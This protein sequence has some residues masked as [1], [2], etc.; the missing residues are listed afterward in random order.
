MASIDLIIDN[1][2]A[3]LTIN[4][5]AKLNCLTWE[6]LQQLQQHLHTIERAGDS[7]RLCLLTA[8]ESRAFCAGAD[9][10]DW[11]KLSARD[12]SQHWLRQGNRIF[13]HFAQLPMPTIAV[14][15]QAV[16]GGGLELIACCDTR[17]INFKV[18]FALPETA[19]GVI[20]GWSGTQRICHLLPETL[21]KNMVLFGQP[22]NA[23]QAQDSGFAHICEDVYQTANEWQVEVLKR[24]PEANRIAKM[25][26]HAS[27]G[28]NTSDMI[29][30]LGGGFSASTVDK[31]TGVEAFLN[32]KPPVF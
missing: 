1:Q 3:T 26:I 22:M 7:I 28:E 5:P 29:D 4:N 10:S 18:T 9:I 15:E 13:S 21:L 24:S 8:A 32:K 30:A 23:T 27:V 25:M 17:L 6:M 12:F 16:M 19:I 20:P 14:I 11:G 2:V 31:A